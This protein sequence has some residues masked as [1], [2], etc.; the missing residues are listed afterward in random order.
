MS[1]PSN[2]NGVISFDSLKWGLEFSY[3]GPVEMA[4]ADKGGGKPDCSDSL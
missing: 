2:G 1:N 3:T 4:M